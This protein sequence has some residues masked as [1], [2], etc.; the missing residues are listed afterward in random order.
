MAGVLRAGY[1]VYTAWQGC[2]VL[3]TS[4]TRHGRGAACW[5]LAG[6]VLYRTVSRFP[7]RLSMC[8][9]VSFY[10]AFKVFFFSEYIRVCACVRVRLLRLLRLLRRVFLISWC[11]Y[12]FAHMMQAYPWACA[13]RG[14]P[15]W[16]GR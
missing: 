12:C 11:C 6:V 1:L 15:R 13:R 7:S 9:S 5:L 16:L 8:A 10:W 2:C 3:A 4:Y 14:V